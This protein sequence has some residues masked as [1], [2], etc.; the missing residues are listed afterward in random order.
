MTVKR[1]AETFGFSEKQVLA[2]IDKG[3]IPGTIMDQ[4]TRAWRLPENAR[5]PYT[6]ARAKSTGA[7]YQSI[8]RACVKRKGVC[9]ALYGLNESEFRFY[10]GQLEEA[11]FI[12]VD[13][14]WNPPSYYA[15]LKSE[16]F[17][18]SRKPS[19]ALQAALE[20]ISEAA[21]KG[22]AEGMM[23]KIMAG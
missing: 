5:P 20:K 18:K 16:E 17:L 10:I 9:A 19:K 14:Q 8:V 23:T 12:S 6:G 4:E 11:G 21:A 22:M 7:I 2:W 3:W 1:F 13:R 15:T